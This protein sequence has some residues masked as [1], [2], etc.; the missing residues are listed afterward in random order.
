MEKVHPWA[1]SPLW[2]G[3]GNGINGYL[4]NRAIRGGKGRQ[5]ALTIVR[6]FLVLVPESVA[7]V[8]AYPSGRTD[9]YAVVQRW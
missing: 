8:P 9:R 6:K 3:P 2:A 7:S 1:I 4:S 5:A